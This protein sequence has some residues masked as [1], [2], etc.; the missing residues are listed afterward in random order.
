MCQ[1][2]Y[3]PTLTNEIRRHPSSLGKPITP[4]VGNRYQANNNWGNPIQ[5]QY[6]MHGI[7]QNYP[8]PK[9]IVYY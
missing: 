6:Y 4:V 7:D 2:P 8:E 5:P 9:V 3:V 1:Q